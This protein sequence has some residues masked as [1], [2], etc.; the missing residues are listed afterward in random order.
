MDKKVQAA[1]LFI[2]AVFIF[3][4]GIKFGGPLIGLVNDQK[5]DEKQQEEIIIPKAPEDQ[6]D[7]KPQEI[8]VHVS[9]AVK[10]PGLYKLNSQAR[11]NDALELAQPLPSADIDQLNLAAKLSDGQKISVPASGEKS[12]NQ[13]GV[14]NSEIS[15]GNATE[16]SGVT[17]GALVNINTASAQELDALPGIG[18]SYAERIIQYRTENGFFEKPEDIQNVKGIGPKKYED[19]KGRITVN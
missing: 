16:N 3:I 10:K 5:I 14:V 19:M 18:P 1:L 9:G 13:S 2:L 17:T 8:Y 11:V 4:A 12:L 7:V 6:A 15:T